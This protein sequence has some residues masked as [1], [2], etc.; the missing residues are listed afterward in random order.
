MRL[1]PENECDD[2]T[3]RPEAVISRPSALESISGELEIRGT[4]RGPNYGGYLV[5]YGLSHDPLGWGWIQ[6]MRSHMVDNDLLARWDTSELPGGP[7]TIRLLVFGP[8][9]PFTSENDPV[10]IETRVEIIVLEPTSTPTSTPTLTPTPTETPTPTTTPS[11]S[12]TGT[13]SATPTST[14]V[15]TETLNAEPPATATSTQ[16]A[17]V[18]PPATATNT[19]ES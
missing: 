8:D 17:P 3:P 14:P 18:Q 2:D 13:S 7:A 9:N 19:P 10:M 11:P 16:I 5:D 4:A 15:P 12:P 6:D 1:A